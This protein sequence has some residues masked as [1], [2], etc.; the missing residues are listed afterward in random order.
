METLEAE[1]FWPWPTYET[2]KERSRDVKEIVP[3]A[4]ERYGAQ[5][6]LAQ[7]KDETA[8]YYLYSEDGTIGNMELKTVQDDRDS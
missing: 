4:D 7:W 5:A 8:W 2:Y 3:Q 6:H 1:A